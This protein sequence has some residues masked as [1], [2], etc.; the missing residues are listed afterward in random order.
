MFNVS[1]RLLH[2]VPQG[3][4][5]AVGVRAWLNAKVDRFCGVPSRKRTMDVLFRI[6]DEH[7]LFPTFSLQEG[8][9]SWSEEDL[10]LKRYARPA[11]YQAMTRLW[12]GGLP[13]QTL[14]DSGATV[15]AIPEEVAC[16][17]ISRV[18]ERVESGELKVS[19]AS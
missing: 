1:E 3:C 7:Q 9:D 18:L 8:L 15:S 2:E 10:T 11:G 17:I 19:D 13:V 6:A 14:L 12:F 16:L 4:Q 5:E